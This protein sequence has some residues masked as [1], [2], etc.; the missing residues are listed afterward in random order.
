MAI[1]RMSMISPANVWHVTPTAVIRRLH[2]SVANGVMCFD[3][4]TAAASAT[5]L[6]PEEKTADKPCPALQDHML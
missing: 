4:V 6:R 2:I 3:R 1:A 5:G